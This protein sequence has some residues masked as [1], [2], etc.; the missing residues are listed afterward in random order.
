MAEEIMETGNVTYNLISNVPYDNPVKVPKV[1]GYYLL[2]GSRVAV[3]LSWL[4]FWSSIAITAIAVVV[5]LL[6]L[7]TR[8]FG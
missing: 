5:T 2:F 4:C 1:V 3:A 6:Y 7:I 8:L